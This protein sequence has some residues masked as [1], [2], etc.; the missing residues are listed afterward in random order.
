[1]FHEAEGYGIEPEKPSIYLPVDGTTA[2]T[3]LVSVTVILLMIGMWVFSRN[4][5]RELT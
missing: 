5:Y 4:E 2:V 1:M 3:V